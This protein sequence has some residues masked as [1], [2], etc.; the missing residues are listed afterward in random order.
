M[1]IVVVSQTLGSLGDEIG[2]ELARTL[3]YQFADREILLEAAE[4]F[5]EGVPVLQ[6]ATEE[7]PTLW[8]RFA[9]TRDPYLAYVGAIVWEIA[10]RGSVVIVGRGAAFCVASVRHALRVRITAPEDLRTKRVEN[11]QGLT[12]DAAPGVVRQSDRDRAA[13]IKFLYDVDWD[14]PFALRSRLQHRARSDERRRPY[15]RGSS[16]ERA[17]PADHGPSA[18]RS[19]TAASPLGRRPLSRKPSD[20]GPSN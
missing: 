13:R 11:Q 16:Q 1:S 14:S 19:R 4:R 17:L 3:S 10:A 12:P 15:P 2:R 8:E 9:G 5:R 20:Q 7:K 6:H 18:G